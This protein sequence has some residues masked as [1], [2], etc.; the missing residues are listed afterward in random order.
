MMKDEVIFKQTFRGI[1][2][3]TSHVHR[4]S[5]ITFKVVGA[6][7]IIRILSS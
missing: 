5:T 7:S 4:K 3:A 1:H 6:Y 2:D